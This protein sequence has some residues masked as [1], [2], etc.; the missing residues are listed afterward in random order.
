MEKLTRTDRF[1][2]DKGFTGAEQQQARDG[3][4]QFEREQ[5]EEEDPFGLEGFM[6]GGNRKRPLDKIGSSGGM[7]AG[8]GSCCRRL[9]SFTPFIQ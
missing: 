1:K 9:K 3:P 6:S 4:V 8:A 7:A 5:L 2:A